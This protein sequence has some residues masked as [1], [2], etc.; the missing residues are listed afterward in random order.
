MTAR[1]RLDPPDFAGRGLAVDLRH[2]DIHENQ[3]G[4]ECRKGLHR[5]LPVAGECQ[6]DPAG[7]QHLRQNQLIGAVVLGRQHPHRPRRDRRGGVLGLG[8][9]RTDIR[10][11]REQQRTRIGIGQQSL[12]RIE[13]RIRLRAE[14]VRRDEQDRQIVPALGPHRLGQFQAVH[15]GHGVLGDDQVDVFRQPV[16]RQ[17]PAGDGC[18]LK[19]E[20]RQLPGHDLAAGMLAR[21]DKRVTQRGT[22]ER[23]RIGC[24]VRRRQ[25]DPKAKARPLAFAAFNPDGAAHQRDQPL[26][27]GQPQAGPLELA[28]PGV[29]GLIELAED[30][31]DLVGRDADAGV[32]DRDVDVAEARLAVQHPGHT[33]QH[34]PFPGELDG[35][36]GEICQ[37]LPDAPGIA[38]KAG[39]QEQVIV[40][41]DR[42]PL[43]ARRRL[44]QQDNLVHAAFQIELGRV[45]NQLVGL[46]LRIVEN[47]VDDHQQRLART[48]D[49]AGI[50]R[51]F[52]IQRRVEQQLGHAD[53][54]VHR[55]ADLVAHVRQKRR[56]RPV[57]HLGPFAG[58]P[59]VLFVGHAGGDVQRQAHH[60]AALTALVDQPDVFAVPP[61]QH[62]GLRVGCQPALGHHRAPIGRGQIAGVDQPFV[63]QQLQDAGIGHARHHFLQP[64]EGGDI[65]G[66]GADHQPVDVEKGETV[67]DRL[68]RMPQPALRDLDLLVRD[69]Q[70]GFHPF[71]LVANGGDF[72]LR[73]A[74]L[75]GQGQRMAAQLAI[76]GRELRLLQ[77]QQP[78]GRQPGATLLGEFVGKA[79]GTEAPPTGRPYRAAAVTHLLHRR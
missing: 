19:S 78:F 23:G 32:L 3:V 70:V 64:V 9:G 40:D 34:V 57:G 21:H 13:G 28:R 63:G 46:D 73:L 15:A 35:I 65:G 20:L 12:H 58:G 14:R 18:H 1:F 11:P 30:V 42:Q 2:R 33:D 52:L 67:L 61:A 7:F 62:D 74:D 53:N 71:V 38:Q 56:F 79:H 4:P 44:Q 60:V 45:K 49:R 55:R 66:V 68:D 75:P 48:L 54:P 72:G 26:A 47:V 36:A 5:F 17:R 77:F 25:A 31:V 6:V 39:R 51:L 50:Q 29:V 76:R 69:G 10:Q 43:V 22:Q 16:Q 27:D 59:E 24:D 8:A 37:Y 41:Q